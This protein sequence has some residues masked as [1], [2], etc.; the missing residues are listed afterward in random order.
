MRLRSSQSQGQDDKKGS[1]GG[2]GGRASRRQ[3]R[4]A[5]ARNDDGGSDDEEERNDDGGG[6]V[7]AGTKKKKTGGN[8]RRSFARK[9]RRIADAASAEEEE[10]TEVEEQETS[11]QQQRRASKKA[12]S[13]KR[14][15]NNRVAPKEASSDD[16]DGSSDDEGGDKKK[17][18]KNQNP[19]SAVNHSDVMALMMQMLPPMMDIVSRQ[20]QPQIREGGI[21]TRLRSNSGK[22]VSQ[23]SLSMASY[24]SE[25]EEEEEEDS[26][27]DD[28]YDE[29]DDDCE[30]MREERYFRKLPL[31]KQREYEQ[32][33]KKLLRDADLDVPLRFRVLDS[34]MPDDAKQQCL[35][36]I[37]RMMGE[38]E[39]SDSKRR[40]WLE[41]LLRIPFGRY[42]EVAK[43]RVTMAA[44]IHAAKSR[45]D[46]VV[47]GNRAVKAT[48]QEL[49][50]QAMTSP[51]G[52]PPVIGL[53]GEPGTGKTTL[54]RLGIA[55]C[56]QRPFY[57]ISCGGMMDAASLR[58]HCYTWEGSMPGAVV[59][60][61]VRSGCLDPVILLDEVD[62]LGSD[63]VKR[64][65][66]VQNVLIHLLDPTQNRE[67]IDEHYAGIPIDLS[68]AV[69][70]LSMNNASNLSPVLRDR[71][72]LLQMDTPKMQDKVEI[73]STFLVPA[74]MENVGLDPEDL[75]FPR[76]TLHHAVVTGGEE[77]GVRQLKQSIEGVSRRVN[78]LSLLN[79]K[80]LAHALSDLAPRDAERVTKMLHSETPM[81]LDPEL[82]DI[83]RP[84]TAGG[85]AR[86]LI[87]SM[88]L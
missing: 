85:G 62:K 22:A 71:I 39:S 76:E 84:I 70:V 88:Y 26:D 27:S 7:A 23:R 61:V 49:V 28:T 13:S 44:Q 63:S 41:T 48:L 82:Y 43:K 50:A 32:Q 80:Q 35:G 15:F 12:S 2:G 17:N 34:A 73:A 53:V 16:D 14:G 42:S 55:D 8:V 19:A 78:M 79:G 1:G 86:G 9:R 52:R 58:G 36:H 51:T 83:L 60:A 20:S 64:G 66:E 37:R 67:F 45:L 6:D 47:H 69:F 29:D 46:G 56:L 31:R 59:N 30:A 11:K 40:A 68:R 65:N 25:E 10:E 5:A 72:H 18:Q 4:A 33:E 87:P 24:T 81:R 57:Q 21:Q 75:V 38:D 77:A 54:A 3:R 74:C